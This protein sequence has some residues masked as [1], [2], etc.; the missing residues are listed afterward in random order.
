MT[1]RERLSATVEVE[2]LEAGRQAV[3]DGR[4]DSLSAWVNDALRRHA[5]HDQ[6]M[7]ALDDFLEGY[8]AEH[9]VIT[10][11][12][13][14]AATRRARSRATVVRTPSAK[15]GRTPKRATTGAA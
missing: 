6:R 3:A 14:V 2:L 12:E 4:A 13:I 15:P 7:K 9:G 5:A 1:S 11:S 10:E 8:E